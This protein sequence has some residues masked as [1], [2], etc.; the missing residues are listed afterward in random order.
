MRFLFLMVSA[1][2]ALIIIG[3]LAFAQAENTVALPEGAW[4]VGPAGVDGMIQ[5]S[6]SPEDCVMQADFNNGLRVT[7]KATDGQL[8]ALRLNETR[9]VGILERVR[10]FV[11]LGLGQNSYALQS[12]ME[13]GQ[14]DST[15][16]SVPDMAKKMMTLSMFRLKLGF[17]NVYFST[18]GFGD[19]YKRLLICMGQAVKTLPVV[20]ET[21]QPEAPAATLQNAENTMPAD[22][23]E[24]VEQLVLDNAEMELKAV[25]QG[26]RNVPLAMALPMIVPADYTFTM[27]GGV[28]PMA[29]VTWEAGDLWMTTLQKAVMPYDYKV[30][31]MA[32]E[33]RIAPQGA[34]RQTPQAETMI[35]KAVVAAEKQLP[36]VKEAAPPQAAAPSPQQPQQ[37]PQSPQE[38][39][40][41]AA[42]GSRLS[43]VLK[44]WAAREGVKAHIGLEADPV[45][46]DDIAISGSFEAAVNHLLKTVGHGSLTPTA[47]VRNAQGRIT[48]VAGYRTG[49]F[50]GSPGAAL[51]PDDFDRWR[52]LEGTDLKNVL[53]RWSIKEGVDFIWD[54]DQ[55]FLIRQSVKTTAD[56][57][58]AVALLLSQF[59][60]QAIRPVAQLNKDP[61]TGKTALI[62]RLNGAG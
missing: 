51:E 39:L 49:R 26:G 53:R 38:P 41:T 37:Q 30:F 60:E 57:P 33:I 48:H 40:W 62:V 17:D 5:A 13:D 45:L 34:E 44:D 19:G 43:D 9:S 36:A 47:L 56:Y 1:Y 16:M 7:F 3:N 2:V 8:V 61:Q 21:Q 22:P 11:G 35:A 18:E 50:A 32:D 23:V 31:I 4:L 27:D 54:I 6:G 25:G 55:S 28:N 46:T 58:E 10:G 42:K 20:D 59:E 14:V 12:R 29:E 52:A 24:A 15:L